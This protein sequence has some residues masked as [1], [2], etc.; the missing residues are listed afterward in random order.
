MTSTRTM[1]SAVWCA[2]IRCPH[3]Q[4]SGV[5]TRHLMSG[6]SWDHTIWSRRNWWEWCQ[7][8]C[9]MIWVV[10]SVLLR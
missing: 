1:N 2:V 7:H 10:R 6:G 3:S 5:C 8:Q 4:L 9:H